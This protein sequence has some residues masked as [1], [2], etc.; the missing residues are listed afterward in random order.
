VYVRCSRTKSMQAG[1]RSAVP[2]TTPTMK[3]GISVGRADK[4]SSREYTP[5][6]LDRP[7][8]RASVPLRTAILEA[9]SLTLSVFVEGGTR[10]G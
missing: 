4:A 9:C 3:N 7:H 2:R 1:V 8:T 5:K 6:K 10:M